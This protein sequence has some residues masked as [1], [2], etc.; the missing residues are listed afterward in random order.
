MSDDLLHDE[1]FLSDQPGEDG[2]LK[3]LGKLLAS[4]DELDDDEFGPEDD[5]AFLSDLPDEEEGYANVDDNLAPD[6]LQSFD[7]LDDD[8]FDPEK[9]AEEIM[10]DFS[11]QLII[12]E[13]DMIEDDGFDLDELE[14]DDTLYEDDFLEDKKFYSDEDYYDHEDE[15]EGNSSYEDDYQF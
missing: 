7:D 4:F 10:D 1:E 3:D 14:G 13:E 12:E 6:D 9:E 15:D 11:V 8:D 2:T 5:V